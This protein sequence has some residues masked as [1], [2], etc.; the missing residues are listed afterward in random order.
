MIDYTVIIPTLNAG[1]TIVRLTDSLNTQSIKPSLIYIIDSSSDDETVSLV[2]D[3]KNVVVDVIDRSD[4]DHG[5]TRDYAFRKT[6][7]EFVVFM[8]QDALPVNNTCM[9]SLLACFK[10]ESIAACSARQIAYDKSSNYEKSVRYYNYPS[11]SKTWNKNDVGKLGISSFLISDVA[12]AYRRSAY[13]SVGGF[14]YPIDT[15]EDM[16]MAAKL[17]D[18]NYC[19]AYCADASVY[20]SHD[21]SF[22]EQYH[23]NYVIGRTLERYKDR[24]NG[25]SEMSKGGSL[26]KNVSGDLLKEH[27]YPDE[28]NFIFDCIARFTGNRIGRLS[29][30]LNHK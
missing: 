26:F 15:N 11:V 6:S 16:L 30:K 25:I 2:R 24:L 27:K 3:Y 20:H 19:L 21:Y 23:R 1:S 5:K 8:T 18:K 7:S 10:D 17:L 28:L 4:F 12:C 22:Y 9:E 14:D 13:L 29:W